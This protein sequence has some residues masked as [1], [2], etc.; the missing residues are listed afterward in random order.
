MTKNT[1]G[2]MR[3]II[4]FLKKNRDCLPDSLIFW[5]Q[6]MHKNYYMGINI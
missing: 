5:S 3:N 6:Q 4:F 2:L 1:I